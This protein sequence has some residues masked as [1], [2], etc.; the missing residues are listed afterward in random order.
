M[1]GVKK[2]KPNGASEARIQVPRIFPANP[3][4]ET[5]ERKPREERWEEILNAAAKIFYDK[6]YE[7]SSLQDIANEVGILK[8]SIYYYIKTKK[9][10]RDHLVNEVHLNGIRM[11]KV[12]S[13]TVGNP[14][15]RLEAMIVAHVLYLCNNMAKTAV[16]LQQFKNVIDDG[17]HNINQHAYRDIVEDVIKLGQDTGYFLPDINSSFAAQVL[18]S[19]LNSL[20][21]WYRPRP[22]SPP[23]AI[24]EH[25]K[26][27]QVRGHVTAKGHRFLDRRIA[28][29]ARTAD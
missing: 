11:I 20:A 26:R 17:N 15:E 29:N 1:T 8:G 13:E 10:L 16:Y 19:S 5:T 14:V 3:P 23:E 2:S 27:I 21:D 12:A 22:S 28:A 24:A 9:D 6:G 18:L 4:R 25:L 7:A